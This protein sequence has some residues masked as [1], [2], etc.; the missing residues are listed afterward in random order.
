MYKRESDVYISNL[1]FYEKEDTISSRYCGEFWDFET[2]NYYLRARYYNPS[3]GRFTQRDSYL[4]RRNDP[5]SL[6]RYTYAKNNPI[7]YR[8][9]WGDWLQSDENLNKDEQHCLKILQ[10]NYCI[11]ILIC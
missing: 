5:L 11:F 10:L 9:P 3:T 1:R 8:D 2:K 6:N 4:G 7:K